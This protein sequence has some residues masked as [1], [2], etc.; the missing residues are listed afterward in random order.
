MLLV[1]LSFVVFV[2]WWSR[3]APEEL[4]CEYLC[5]GA[6]SHCAFTDRSVCTKGCSAGDAACAERCG[7]EDQDCRTHCSSI[8]ELG[9]E[10]RLQALYGCL[11]LRCGD[12]ERDIWHACDA[13]RR[14]Y[15]TC[16]GK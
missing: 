4:S 15:E 2:V 5:Q 6:Q 14:A 8:A 10:T 11:I 9:C 3:N 1:S 16:I 13:A 12:P 7:G